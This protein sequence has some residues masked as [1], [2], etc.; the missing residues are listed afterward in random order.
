MP[1]DAQVLVQE[2]RDDNANIAFP[3]VDSAKL[4]TSLGVS[5]NNR[6]FLDAAIYP[7]GYVGRVFLGQVV[8]SLSGVTYVLTNE[9]GVVIA[10]GA[11]TNDEIW[12]SDALGRNAGVLI[13]DPT[14]LPQ[15]WPIGTHSFGT[16]AELVAS[17]IELGADT[18]PTSLVLPDGTLITGDVWVVGDDGVVI[19]QAGDG[20]T[21]VNMVG[22][23]LFQRRLCDPEFN[24][25][26][27]IATPFFTKTYLQALAIPVN[28]A[29]V[30]VAADQYGGFVISANDAMTPDS[31]LRIYPSDDGTV[32]IELVGKII[33]QA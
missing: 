28:G 26:V 24:S 7:P 4:K 33:T 12:F 30:E 18:A 3:F 25:L 27:S 20:S 9:R 13:V 10:S 8:S 32:K 31:V 19:T 1:A 17:V 22:D 16:G 23:P 5:L 15:N 2:W 14:E 11:L 21:Q 6:A 29:W